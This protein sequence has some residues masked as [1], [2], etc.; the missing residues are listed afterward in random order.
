MKVLL[1]GAS[2]FI[3]RSIAAKS[4]S[5]VE[6]TA[7]YF[8]NKPDIVG[9]NIE[10]LDC[11]DTSLDWSHIVNQYD[12]IIIAARASAGT[13]SARE[14][15]SHKMQAVFSRLTHAVRESDSNT[16]LV[17]VNGSL[18][19]G[20]RGDEIVQSTDSINPI[21]FAESYSIAE[22]PFRHFL[23]EDNNIAI[24]RAPWVIGNGSWFVQMYLQANKIPIIKHGNQW[25]ALV[26]VDDLADY[27][28]NVVQS[29]KNGIFHPK[30]TYRCRQRDFAAIVQEV[31]QKQTHTLGRFKLR[32]VEK[33][34][35]ESIVASI[36]MDDGMMH[37]SENESSRENL[38]AIIENIY[39]GFS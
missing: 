19:Y 14:Q 27:V 9:M 28:W 33:Q 31:T 17:A 26:F 13:Q 29:Q 23:E 11:L 8:S 16:F 2:G 6:L 18:S 4:P 39:S 24:I 38:K 3:G 12:C 1:L 30:L 10:R 32:A 35:R 37:Q 36:R 34:M 20:D 5:T 7:T 21:G 25:M 15:L 22:Q